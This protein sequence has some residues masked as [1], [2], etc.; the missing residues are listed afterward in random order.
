MAFETFNLWKSA[1]F[2]P[3]RTFAEQKKKA[4][5][6]RAVL[7]IA[8]YGALYILSAYL[9]LQACLFVLR[10]FSRVVIF[11]DVDGTIIP[12]LVSSFGLLGVIAGMFVFAFFSVV[13]AFAYNLLLFPFARLLGGKGTFRQQFHLVALSHAFFWFVMAVALA[14]SFI[15]VVGESIYY[16][17]NV[18]VFVYGVYLL[19]IALREAHGY[20][21][22]EAALTW[23]FLP[24]VIVTVFLLR[25]LV[26]GA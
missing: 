23:L 10:L 1:F 6:K 22:V 17:A 11:S 24:L 19:T 8:E 15:P 5:Y 26:Y 2:S 13:V 3:A 21:T 9:V 18:A 4:S 7:W 14:V 12:L 16:V 20:G 25:P